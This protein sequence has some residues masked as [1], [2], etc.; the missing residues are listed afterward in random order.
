MDNL[1]IKM[2]D[3]NHIFPTNEAR[4]QYDSEC[5]LKTAED[6]EDDGQCILEERIV[7]DDGEVSELGHDTVGWFCAEA[8][9]VLASES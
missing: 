9:A 8:R 4:D 1:V 2:D 5:Y 3:G 6:C 7:G